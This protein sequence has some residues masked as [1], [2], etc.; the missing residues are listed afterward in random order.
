V[1]LANSS[2]RANTACSFPK[3]VGHL[4]FHQQKE[5]R[6]PLRY[7][8]LLPLLETEQP[9]PSLELFRLVPIVGGTA[10]R[11]RAAA[12]PGTHH[13]LVAQSLSADIP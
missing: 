3:S 2:M 12:P 1:W 9:R 4:R 11:P 10:Y 6:N 8:L 5:G 7:L 13:G